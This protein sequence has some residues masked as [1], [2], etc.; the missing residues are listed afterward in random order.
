M[1][2]SESIGRNLAITHNLL[3]RYLN[4]HGCHHPHGNLNITPVQIRIM[5]YLVRHQNKP[6]AQKD[7]AN[8][9]TIRRSTVSGILKTM[10]KNNLIVRTNIENDSKSKEIALTP[11]VYEKALSIKKQGLATEK[12]LRK[13]IT[14]SDLLIFLQVLKTIQNNLLNAERNEKHV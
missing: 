6:I 9:L 4:Y 1:S 14:E 2:E 3:F 13:N 11:S 10:E 8:L 5:E 12:I 7:V